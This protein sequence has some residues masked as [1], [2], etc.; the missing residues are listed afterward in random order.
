MAVELI[1]MGLI[2]QA[3]TKPTLLIEFTTSFFSTVSIAFFGRVNS[4]KKNSPHEISE[5]VINLRLK[6][7]A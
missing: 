6:S 1:G 5:S 7:N 2:N 4:M 3:P